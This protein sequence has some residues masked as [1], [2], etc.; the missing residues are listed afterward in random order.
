MLEKQI[1]KSISTYSKMY[2]YLTYKFTSPS[3]KSVPDRIFINK[4]GIVLF[5]EFKSPGRKTTKLQSYTI[6]KL[7]YNNA[8][9]YIIDNISDGKQLIERYA[10]KTT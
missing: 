10:S 7:K 4:H 2:D 9:V 6:E 1:E 5:V 3:N 8:H